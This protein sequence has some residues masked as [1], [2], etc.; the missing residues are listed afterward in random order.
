MMATT[1][2]NTKNVNRVKA[3]KIRIV[4]DL[5]DL[6]NS[7]IGEMYLLIQDG[8]ADTNKIHIRIVGGWLKTAALT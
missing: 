8:H 6:K 7:E 1:V 3:P 4:N 5:P 2:A